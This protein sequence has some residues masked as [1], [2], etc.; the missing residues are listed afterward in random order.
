MII[1]RIFIFLLSFFIAI[2]PIEVW[3]IDPILPGG[4]T[5]AAAESDIAA[6]LG[7]G[8]SGGFAA[9]GAGLAAALGVA[10]VGVGS[11]C[12]A[13]IAQGANLCGANPNSPICQALATVNASCTPNPD[14]SF[15]KSSAS[16][17]DPAHGGLSDPTM[18][19]RMATDPP[20]SWSDSASGACGA[21]ESL[22]AGQG[23]TGF[24]LANYSGTL[25]CHF[26]LPNGDFNDQG[27]E[28]QPKMQ[29]P[30]GQIAVNGVC[31]TTPTPPPPPPPPNNPANNVPPSDIGGAIAGSPAAAAAIGAA[32]AAAASTG[33]SGTSGTFNGA[34]TCVPAL[35]PSNNPSCSGFYGTVNN[36][37]YC[38][39]SPLPNTHAGC[40]GFFGTA[41]GVDQCIPV[42]GGS[43][44][45]CAG[46]MGSFN[47]T[48]GCIGGS[49][50]PAT[51]ADAAAQAAAA[52]AAAASA[53]ANPPAARSCA[54]S[55]VL[56]PNGIC[57]NPA[58]P[59][60]PAN[61]CSSGFVFYANACV[62][63]SA[64]NP[65]IPATPNN[66]AKPTTPTELPAFC[67]WASTVCGLVTFI[68]DVPNAPT[69]NN[70]V[71]IIAS[72]SSG[73]ASVDNF[74]I[75]QSLFTFSA[76]CPPDIPMNFSL[77]G[78]SVPLTFKYASICTFMQDIRPFVIGSAFIA[79]AYI[80]SGASRGNGGG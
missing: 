23:I 52:A 32:A 14:G 74:N 54:G 57:L 67:T 68:E 11:F 80:V 56:Q 61:N 26:A 66:P 24:S 76:S 16:P 49:D 39:P 72:P 51:P 37:S 30:D 40:T 63:A 50:A 79:G 6:T 77:M 25:F 42:I 59:N 70:T 58:L 69:S 27:L 4:F 45:G 10:A 9:S 7:G 31:P 65:A 3:A 46:T 47:G 48:T 29:C 28:S 75:H 12:I 62:P 8:S 19:Y 20:L 55:F 22:L 78:R 13:S 60:N 2:V 53:L 38:V 33:C 1:K 64:T 71:P 15:P 36:V 43:N 35:A 73:N 34:A 5:S 17:P 41:D 44:S 21:G 18:Q